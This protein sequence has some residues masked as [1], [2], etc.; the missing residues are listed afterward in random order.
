VRSAADKINGIQ[1]YRAN[2]LPRTL[3]PKPIPTHIPVQVIV[4]EQDAFATPQLV[5]E[6]P[7]PWVADLTV[8]RVDG[9]HWVIASQPQAIAE[10][11]RD[12]LQSRFRTAGRAEGDTRRKTS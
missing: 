6:A 5:I 2:M 3:A 1:L 12:F 4:V 8:S 7:R 11:T 9:G 10:L